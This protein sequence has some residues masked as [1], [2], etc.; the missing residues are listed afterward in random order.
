MN[1]SDS[2]LSR[3]EMKNVKGGQRWNC[4]CKYHAGTWS[5][6]YYSQA[7]LSTAVNDYCRGGAYCG[8]TQ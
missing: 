1:F 4:S 7:Q 2:A 8:T 3:S 6:K 5:A